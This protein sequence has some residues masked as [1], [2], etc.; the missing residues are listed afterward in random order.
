MKTR[1]I[2]CICL[3]VIAVIAVFT[4]AIRLR[5]SDA[6]YQRDSAD[7]RQQIEN[8]QT[9]TLA[10]E[11]L[12]QMDQTYTA[13]APTH[14]AYDDPM[15]TAEL[16]EMVDAYS[17]VGRLYSG[18]N[19]LAAMP[20]MQGAVIPGASCASV[21]ETAAS[22]Y[23]EK[24][25]AAE[26]TWHHASV[27]NGILLCLGLLG[28]ALSLLRLHGLESEVSEPETQTRRHHRPHTPAPHLT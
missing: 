7:A 23:T 8:A 9:L 24:L 18:L 11:R 27:S 19:A 14:A 13:G 3:A 4:G 12:G 25:Q 5:Q 10:A 16:Y 26:E 15:F 6:N 28:L 21:L 17:D 20:E 22:V 1:K 2:L